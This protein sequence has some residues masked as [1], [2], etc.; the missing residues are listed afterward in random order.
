MHP[1]KTILGSRPGDSQKPR[2]K[3]RRSLGTIFEVKQGER[4]SSGISK[5]FHHFRNTW[6]NRFSPFVHPPQPDP[7]DANAFRTLAKSRRR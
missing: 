5:A 6:K 2:K 3:A 4:P 7:N 1:W